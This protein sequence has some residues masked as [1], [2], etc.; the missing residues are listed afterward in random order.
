MLQ[1]TK[2]F[3]SALACTGDFFQHFVLLAFRLYFGYNFFLAGYQ[4]FHN[5]KETAAFFGQLGIPLADA[6]AYLVASV[7]MACGILLIVGLA[8]RLA[9]IPLIITMIVALLTAHSKGAFQIFSNPSAFLSEMPVS[10]LIVSLVIFVFGAGW[11]S[12]DYLFGRF[13]CKSCKG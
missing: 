4:K 10:Y 9:A 6:Q 7:E 12:L 3:F 5:I 13:C 8:S 1:K 11:F 2:T